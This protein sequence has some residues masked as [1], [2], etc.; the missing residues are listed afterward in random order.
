MREK[1]TRTVLSLAVVVAAVFAFRWTVRT[2]VTR[3]STAGRDVSPREV[4]VVPAQKVWSLVKI[5]PEELR[6]NLAGLA[7]QRRAERMHMPYALAVDVAAQKAESAGWERLDDEN[8]LTFKTLSGMESVYKTP[9]GSI[10]L[11]EVRSI[12][13]D[14]SLMEDYIIPAEMVPAQ[15][16][17]IT[18]D[19]LARRSARQVKMKLPEPIRDVV[20]GSP[21]M[22]ELVERG[23]GAALLVHAV[24]GKSAAAAVKD[25]EAAARRT[26]WKMTPYVDSPAGA[27]KAGW[28]KEN[29]SMHFEAI[30]RPGLFECDINYRFTDDESY[31]PAKG[32]ENNES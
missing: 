7:V 13:G 23:A 24:Y 8:A 3:T 6:I 9:A 25:I 4:R 16:E 20:V 22:T 5:V 15:G 32:Q 19:M 31:I 10:V 17:T 27:P 21:L 29:L 11:R 1:I 18:P 2:A 14:D 12:I 28:T 30:Q 26:G